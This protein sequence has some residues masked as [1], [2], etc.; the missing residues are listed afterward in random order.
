MVPSATLNE[1]L[2]RGKILYRGTG[3][4]ILGLTALGKENARNSVA[5]VSMLSFRTML[6]AQLAKT[7]DDLPS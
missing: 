1:W 5:L 4:R 3:L 2:Q 6:R 7:K